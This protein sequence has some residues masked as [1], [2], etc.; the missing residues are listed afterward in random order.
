VLL[1]AALGFGGM[2]AIRHAPTIELLVSG[3]RRGEVARYAGRSVVNTIDEQPA[4]ATVAGAPTLPLCADVGPADARDLADAMNLMRRTDEGHRLFDQLV[5]E[6]ICVGVEEID[7][8]SGYAFASQSPLTG[9][10]SRSY[11]MVDADLLR[12]GEID[13]VAALL[14]HEATHM[15]RYINSLACDYSQSCTMLANGVELEEELAAHAAEAEWWIAAYGEDG[16]RFAIGYDYGLNRLARAYLDGA[17]AVEAHVSRL[18]GDPREG[19][20]W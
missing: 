12:A 6:N 14:V 9:S 4:F 8:N 16:K 11:I 20:G 2:V 5:D 19:G 10:W 1:I 17:A 3:A 7:Y 13:V 18:R 15:D